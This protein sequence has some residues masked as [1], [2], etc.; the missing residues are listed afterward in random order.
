LNHGAPQAPRG[1]QGKGSAIFAAG[2]V[3]GNVIAIAEVDTIKTLGDFSGTGL[4]SF[5]I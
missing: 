2:V 1:K 3:V 4:V 5:L